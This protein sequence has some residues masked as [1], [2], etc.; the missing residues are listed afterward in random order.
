MVRCMCVCVCTG[1][2]ILF[3]TKT[4]AA[5]VTRWCTDA[6]FDHVAMVLRT[7]EG[8]RTV[9]CTG[10]GIG[11]WILQER[12]DD[13]IIKGVVIRRLQTNLTNAMV[14]S[15]NA[16]L[17]SVKHKPY[18]L[19][20]TL[21]KRMVRTC[22]CCKRAGQNEIGLDGRPQDEEEADLEQQ[23][24]GGANTDGPNK[25]AAGRYAAGA[26]NEFELEDGQP[27]IPTLLP[28]L[29]RDGPGRRFPVDADEV[30]SDDSPR[31]PSS[32]DP[33]AA[34]ANSGRA[35]ASTS[36]SS[37]NDPKR[38]IELRDHES[39][40]THYP[41]PEDLNALHEKPGFFCSSFIAACYMK[42]GLLPAYP[43][44]DWYLPNTFSSRTAI[45]PPL[46][47]AD[48]GDETLIAKP[49]KDTRPRKWTNVYRAG[50]RRRTRNA[51]VTTSAQAAAAEQ[52]RATSNTVEKKT[53]PHATPANTATTGTG[54]TVSASHHVSPVRGR[55]V[56]LPTDVD[57]DLQFGPP[58][59]DEGGYM[60]PPPEPQ[61]TNATL[62]HATSQSTT[63]PPANTTAATSTHSSF[64]D[65]TNDPD[66]ATQQPHAQRTI[67][68]SRSHDRVDVPLSLVR[69]AAA[70]IGDLVSPGSASGDGAPSDPA[71]LLRRPTPLPNTPTSTRTPE[72]TEI[73]QHQHDDQQRDAAG[74]TAFTH[75]RAVDASL[76]CDQ[77]SA[78]SSSS[79]SSSCDASEIRTPSATIFMPQLASTAYADTRPNP[80]HARALSLGSKKLPPLVRVTSNTRNT[81]A[82]MEEEQEQ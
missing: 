79:S 68:P 73:E 34:S 46:I 14:D 74:A 65:E 25:N 8:Y 20:S 36:V 11:C 60:R 59:P 76:Q 64:R 26:S 47:N 33:P 16:F 29:G 35:S 81:P 56:G 22:L 18:R 19:N 66:I 63:P 77:H 53:H 72:R 28:P 48:F 44:I 13:H 41:K 1:D 12:I 42:M 43:P 69:H 4:T 7:S 32:R 10:Q 82:K 58:S 23:A 30:K 24:T 27:P 5:A 17:Q 39:I 57:D 3:R 15:L 50:E 78:A 62:K 45:Q 61:R 21:V 2:L 71:F 9:E 54:T 38:L 49:S 67:P 52:Q 55:P 80:S 37:L 6:P 70:P 31:S 51:P 40:R 75:A